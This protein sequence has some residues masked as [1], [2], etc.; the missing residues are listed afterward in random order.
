MTIASTT[1]QASRKTSVSDRIN[2]LRIVLIIGILL[3]HI[4]FNPENS[5]YLVNTPIFDWFRIY[6]GDILVRSG[7]P[8]LSAISGYLLFRNGPNLN[9]AQ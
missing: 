4:P 2:S 3:E 6:F 7:V 5:P 8:C 1:S 9:T